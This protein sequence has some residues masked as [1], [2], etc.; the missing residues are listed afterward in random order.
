MGE[1]ADRK[2]R[3]AILGDGAA[4]GA[5]SRIAALERIVEQYKVLLE[6]SAALTASTD[7]EETLSL[8]TSLVTE[9][10]D[11]AW[12]DLYDYE[13][14][15]DEFVVIAFY[16]LPEL[17][18]DA[19][20]W[21]GTRY[22]SS[23]WSDLEA[24]V[25]ERR[26]SIWYRDDPQLPERELANMDDWGELSNMSLP[27][28]YRG[29]VIGL[30]D[31]GESRQMRRWTDDDKRVLQAIAD[32]AAIAIVN[33]RAYTALAEQAVTDG[34]TGLFNHRHFNE[35]LRQE[36]TTARRYGQELSLMMLDVDDFKAFNDR[37]G[38]PQGDSVLAELA[39]ILRHGTRNDVDIL[40]R[41]GG[42][43]LVVILPQARANG[44]E[45]TAARNVA[46]RI[47]AA[48]RAHRFESAKGRRDVAMTVSIGV[49]GIGLGGY[50][51]E[52]L[53]GSADKALYLAKH[54]GKDRV[55]VF[56]T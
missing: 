46:E 44:P 21:M 33:A 40:A 31:V 23:S 10:L 39:E 1:A 49:A 50:T 51:H 53:L 20:D 18:I 4:S 25:R 19:S 34:L 5:A 55:S 3:G 37:Y 48:V 43:E 45:P 6:T 13:P 41:Y 38:H 47:A 15:G 42:D 52:E 54:Q 16:Q 9:R 35:H 27:L 7:L 28:V 11:V 8:I 2:G 22:D 24:C 36:V 26:P 14:T 17:E 12:C 30:I 56:G 29:A 32:Q